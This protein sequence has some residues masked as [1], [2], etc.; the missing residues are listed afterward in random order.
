MH[1]ANAPDTRQVL[2]SNAAAIVMFALDTPSRGRA[3]ALLRRALAH[4][5]EN[6]AAMY[7]PSTSFLK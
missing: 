2:L 5:S 4:D 1:V 6:F 7:H 3:E